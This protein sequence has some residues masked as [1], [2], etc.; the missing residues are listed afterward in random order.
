MTAAALPPAHQ[1][2]RR[3]LTLVIVVMSVVIAALD[4]TILNVAIPTILRE[5]HTELP[6]LQWVVTGYSLTFASLLIIGGRL[7][8]IY[9]ARRV[10]IIGASFF[11][12]GS[13]LAAVSQSVPTLFL[14]EALIEGIGASLMLPSTLSILSNT[15]QGRERSTA[16]A[17]WGATGGAAIAFGPV[18][19]GFLT[20]NYSWRWAFG[21]NVII[22]PI[23]I[24]GAMV[25]IRKTPTASRQPRLDFQGAAMIAFGVF[26]FVFGLS[27]GSAYGWLAPIKD[28]TIGG[29]VIWPQSMPVSVIVVT[30]V[31]AVAI[32]T[33]FVFVERAKERSGNDPL[34]EFGLL[35]YKG[36]RYGLL[37]TVVLAMGQFSLLF[38]LPVLLQDG[39]HLTAAQNGLWMLPSGLL[40]IVGAQ[41][42]GRLTRRIG[43]VSVVRIGL[44]FE[45]V[46]LTT[47]A[48]VV[49]PHLTFVSLL[50][51][52]LVF[53][54]GVG[55]ASS[56]L[57]NVILSEIPAAKAGSASGANVT[58][59]QIGAALGI[60]VI[61][62]LI[63]VLTTSHAT[64]SIRASGL[65]PALK[66]R[67]LVAV[68]LDGVNFAPP[69]GATSR[70]VAELRHILESAVAAGARPALFFAATVVAIGAILSLLIPRASLV[71]TTS[72]EF[73]VIET[74][75]AFDSLDL[76]RAATA[77]E[78]NGPADR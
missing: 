30:F 14:G 40:I 65:A 60:A 57:T 3:W 32:L 27:Q 48:L 69:S 62:S 46:G 22:V 26:L 54:F 34:F 21:I 44:L 11:G 25:F 12:V 29:T 61:G 19:G 74:F 66:A 20:T 55:F 68:K 39:K 67:S 59:R 72:P 77:A 75:E 36:F 17:A 53:G 78:R 52:Y 18:V 2:P 49:S 63:S 45:A 16:F 4:G 56:Q 10:F 6:S 28:L 76:Q 24:T 51:G 70:D 43:V 8:D 15:F 7:G 73:E 58:S 37:T 5:F 13:L 35:R 1:D 9:G 33:A 64:S 41:V 23:A 42:G 31:L 71:V 38:V 47:I 50:P